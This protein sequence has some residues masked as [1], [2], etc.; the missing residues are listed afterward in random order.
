[1]LDKLPRIAHIT[2]ATIVLVLA[3][4]CSKPVAGEKEMLGKIKG[5]AS[6]RL[7]D[8]ST[9]SRDDSDEYNPY[10]LKL[11][12]GY[13]VLVF[14][15]NRT[16]CVN[17]TA[18]NIFLARSLTPF[19]GQVIPFFS[20]PLPAKL[21]TNPIN[22]PGQISFAAAADGTSVVIYMNYS[23]GSNQI[24]T[25]TFDPTNPTVGS[26]TLITNSNH[27]DN[28]VIGISA[29][30]T[31]LFSTD[32]NESGYAFSPTAS[33]AADPY[34][35]GMDY[36]TSVT[37]VRQ[38]NSGLQD[39]ILGVSY[40]L[41]YTAAGN[42]W[43]GP[44]A[45]LESAMLLNGMYLNSLSTF[46]VD[47]PSGDIVLFSA[48]DGISD[49]IYVITSH[50]SYDLWYTVPFFGFDQFLAPPPPPEHWFDFEWACPGGLV[51]D[52]GTPGG[53]TGAQC[54][55]VTINAASSYNGSQ[56]GT[57]G[58][59]DSLDFGIQDLGYSFT[60]SAWVYVPTSA[61]C[62]ADCP[63]VANGFVSATTSGFRLNVDSTTMTLQFATSDGTTDLTAD[64]FPGVL[65]AD[66]WHHVAVTA[67]QTGEYALLYVDGVIVSN[68]V[69][70]QTG[71]DTALSIL[72]AGQDGS[73]NFTGDMDDVMTFPYELGPI[74]IMALATTY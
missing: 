70:T 61:P 21:S 32:V 58:S 4:H 20:T 55:G 42:D 74:E 17:C 54:T 72:Q 56:M 19:D 59:G 47:D 67:N 68:N 57:F 40:G 53:W 38:E 73:G 30:G 34:G 45:D 71:Y 43:F 33:I 7:A 29:D 35:Y 2:L 50:T 11:S 62:G 60:L 69:M 16:D 3:T 36:A 14:G 41:S 49:D 22:E 10:L 23:S 6:L 25:G 37:Q 46:Y 48:W 27:Y 12:D 66:N 64:S 31:M 18:H 9:I 15:S 24:H 51:P 63:I 28:T 52:S 13:L 44:I 8:G 65:V 1:M 39:S 26:L 5:K